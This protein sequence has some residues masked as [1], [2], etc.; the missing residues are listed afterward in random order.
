MNDGIFSTVWLTAWPDKWLLPQ[1]HRRGRGTTISSPVEQHSLDSMLTSGTY[2][3][4]LTIRAAGN[5]QRYCLATKN[6]KLTS[7]ELFRVACMD[8]SDP[9]GNIQVEGNMYS[10]FM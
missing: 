1:G 2:H 10:T 7:S 5:K 4:W 3:S 6:V 9:T 8:I